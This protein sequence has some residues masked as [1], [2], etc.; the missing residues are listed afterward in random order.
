MTVRNIIRALV[1][2]LISSR[3]F[4]ILF[5]NLPSPLNK[6]TLWFIAV[7][8]AIIIYKPKLLLQK[9]LFFLFTW[10]IVLNFSEIQDPTI[11]SQLTR[12]SL[13][14]GVSII[15]FHYFLKYDKQGISLIAKYSL[16]FIVITIISSFIGLTLFPEGARFNPEHS[17]YSY[18]VHI[19]KQY[20][21]NRI[22]IGGYGFIYS[23]TFLFPVIYNY[24]AQNK[25]LFYIFIHTLSLIA[26]NQGTAFIQ[27]ILAI[28][29]SINIEKIYRNKVVLIILIF[30]IILIP[31]SLIS[32]LFNK[33]SEYLP[34][35]STVQNRVHDFA[36]TIGGDD[37]THGSQRLDRIP[38]LID[39]IS[40]NFWYGGG[41]STGHVF[42][43]DMLS[44]LGVIRFMLFLSVV[45]YPLLS[46]VKYLPQKT[47]IYYV[48]SLLL[49]V[50]NWFVKNG[51]HVDVTL[52][53]FLISPL[54]CIAST[55]KTNKKM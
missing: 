12:F 27:S 36:L 44:T 43:L 45:F 37:D 13:M 24:L 19:A 16:I 42:W 35:N 47:K 21:Y 52:G 28:I 6:F 40:D 5:Y 51:A 29:V 26:F 49:M 25:K 11:Y 31:L 8:L 50:S 53:I 32:D 22:G 54:I 23:I 14:V 41:K 48:F 30:F 38:F 34:E 3:F 20:F 17:G 4:Y 1:L 55:S 9:S 10:L 18:D 39:E 7:P 46:T 2:M 33:M 15:T